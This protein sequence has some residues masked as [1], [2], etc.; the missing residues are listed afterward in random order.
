MECPVLVVAPPRLAH[1][2][3]EVIGEHFE[4]EVCT[5]VAKARALGMIGRYLAIVQVEGLGHI[6]GDAPVLRVRDA[7]PDVLDQLATL[8]ARARPDQRACAEG[9]EPLATLTYDEYMAAA[10]ARIVR[11]YLLALLR[12]HR[13]NVSEAARAAGVLRETL[14]RLIRRHHVDPGWFR[15]EPS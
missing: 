2:L 8:R 5:E 10:R 9:L 7:S 3:S 14:H 4:I 12:R 11:D 6:A 1:K 15:D 13:G